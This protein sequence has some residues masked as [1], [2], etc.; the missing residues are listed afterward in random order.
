MFVKVFLFTRPYHEVVFSGDPYQP[1]SFVSFKSNTIQK[2]ECVEMFK[3]FFSNKSD[4]WSMAYMCSMKNLATF[5][6]TYFTLIWDHEPAVIICVWA[7]FQ[8]TSW[9]MWW[10]TVSFLAQAGPRGCI[11]VILYLGERTI[12]WSYEDTLQ[13]WCQIR[14]CVLASDCVS[15]FRPRFCSTR[16][17]CRSCNKPANKLRHGSQINIESCNRLVMG[18]NHKCSLCSKPQLLF[19]SMYWYY[20]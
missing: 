15:L 8:F 12:S 7:A 9:L 2:A 18:T 19:F 20:W 5:S 3:A 10:A 16:L 4:V 14:S 6:R 1:C 11:T 17:R 13:H